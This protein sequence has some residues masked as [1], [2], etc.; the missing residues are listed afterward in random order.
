MNHFIMY[1][2]QTK[3]KNVLKR[4]KELDNILDDIWC[5]YSFEKGK[6]Q[7]NNIIEDIPYP[8]RERIDIEIY[9]VSSGNG[10]IQSRLAVKDEMSKYIEYLIK[11]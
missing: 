8:F 3:N 10:I 9:H 6:R 7:W 11:S 2:T 1:R 5:T 4:I